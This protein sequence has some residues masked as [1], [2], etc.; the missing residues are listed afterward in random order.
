M[1][2]NAELNRHVK[3]GNYDNLMTFLIRGQHDVNRSEV[4][5]DT[6]LHLA[7]KASQVTILYL[8]LYFPVI[9]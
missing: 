8:V 6:A 2:M 4:E 5:G 7:C 3:E 1:D 9:V